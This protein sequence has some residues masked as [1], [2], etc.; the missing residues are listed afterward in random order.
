[1]LNKVGK[2]LAIS[3][4]QSDL[5][6]IRYNVKCQNTQCMKSEFGSYVVCFDVYSKKIKFPPYSMLLYGE[7]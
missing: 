5:Q 3:K 7:M 1:M 2:R 6:L 4:W